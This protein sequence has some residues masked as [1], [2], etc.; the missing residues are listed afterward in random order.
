MTA[1]WI[2]DF[3]GAAGTT[4][5]V[6]DFT[7]DDRGRY[8]IG[9]GRAHALWQF[10]IV[11]DRLGF[12]HSAIVNGFTAPLGTTEVRCPGT[13][14]IFFT[15]APDSIDVQAPPA[16]LTINGQGIDATCGMPTLDFYDEN[17]TIVA[18][19]TATEVA[20][21]GTWVSAATPYMDA[22]SYYGG[23]YTIGVNN[24]MPDGTSNPVGYAAVWLYNS[25]PPPPPD[26]CLN[27]APSGSPDQPMTQRPACDYNNY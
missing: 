24:A 2:R 8:A 16:T 23:T 25:N 14:G 20:S 19:T 3:Q 27:Q 10:G 17:G 18:Q 4:T 7:T 15:S 12:C 22:S 9:G 13:I 11:G 5:F 26:P 6:Q 21:D 1:G